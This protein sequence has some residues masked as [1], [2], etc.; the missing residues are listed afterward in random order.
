MN[1]P[2]TPYTLEDCNPPKGYEHARPSWDRLRATVEALEEAK[3]DWSAQRNEAARCRD[4]W[5]ESAALASE[6]RLEAVKLQVRVGELEAVL[7][8]L[9][10]RCEVQSSP[11]ALW[12]EVSAARA[13][14]IKADGRG[15]LE[16]LRALPLL[17]SG[18]LAQAVALAAPLE[19]ED[20]GAKSADV[21]EGFCPFASEVH[22]K[23]VPV[24]LCRGC[25]KKRNDET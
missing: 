13:L 4:G 12:P 19:C 11:V 16:R 15:A 22:N 8:G 17:K 9:T 1:K 14:L 3:A 25:Y 6:A 18:V 5:A 21:T 24:T 20:C 7:E 2:Y 23:R 10:S